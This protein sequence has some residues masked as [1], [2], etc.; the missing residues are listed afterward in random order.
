[1]QIR[2]PH[3]GLPVHIATSLKILVLGKATWEH[4]EQ[5]SPPRFVR[6][7][8]SRRRAREDRYESPVRARLAPEAVL[9]LWPLDEP[10]TFSRPLYLEHHCPAMSSGPVCDDLHGPDL[11]GCPR[12]QRGDERLGIVI[13]PRGCH[14]ADR[15][16]GS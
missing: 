8:K 12:R 9:A 4:S 16:C 15:R 7:D 14:P 6:G 5:E 2:Q 13:V 11:G 3:S 10:A 1:V